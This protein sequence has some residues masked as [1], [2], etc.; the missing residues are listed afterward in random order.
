MDERAQARARLDTV[1]GVIL[2]AQANAA[3]QRSGQDA[4]DAAVRGAYA[5]LMEK[6]DGALT[7]RHEVVLT[8]RGLAHLLAAR[9]AFSDVEGSKTFPRV[10]EAV[11][12]AKGSPRAAIKR[13][14][15][16]IPPI[17]LGARVVRKPRIGAYNEARLIGYT[18]LGEARIRFIASGEETETPVEQLDQVTGV[19][20][21]FEAGPPKKDAQGLV[22]LR[23]VPPGAKRPDIALARRDG[24]GWERLDP[25]TAEPIGA[26]EG[27]ILGH[28][29]VIPPAP[30]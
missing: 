18:D 15:R 11:A 17:P 23:L 27:T 6:I 24:P 14:E 22:W 5:A 2:L 7:E 26:I 3:G 4:N 10:K 21:R 25:A 1:I 19:D 8:K 30:A 29:A 9:A 12:S 16:A 28:F 20:P 13:T